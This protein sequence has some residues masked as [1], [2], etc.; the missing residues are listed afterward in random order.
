MGHV[1]IPLVSDPALCLWCASVHTTSA[2][3][4]W[5]SALIRS[6]TLRHRSTLC[7]RSLTMRHRGT[8][9]LL[10]PY[11]KCMLQQQ[12]GSRC[13]IY[14]YIYISLCRDGARNENNKRQRMCRD[15]A[16]KGNIY[17]P[18]PNPYTAI[19]PVATPSLDDLVLAES[20][21]PHTG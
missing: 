20:L 13:R 10:H 8:L 15:G 11:S 16:E 5:R 14:V 7:R 17:M 9:C 2:F 21:V 18:T 6:L 19:N 4:K 1:D 3:S 12:G